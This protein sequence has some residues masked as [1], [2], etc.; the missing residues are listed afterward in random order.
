MSSSELSPQSSLLLHLSFDA[1]HR[2]DLHLKFIGPSQGS[3]KRAA[4]A[5][6]GTCAVRKPH[7][8]KFSRQQPSELQ[9]GSD[10][11][12]YPCNSSRL[13]LIC[14]L[15]VREWSSHLPWCS[16]MRSHK[17]WLPTRNLG[18]D[19]RKSSKVLLHTCIPHRKLRIY[20]VFRI[21]KKYLSSLN[22]KN[23]W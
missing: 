8:L 1:I 6:P 22:K 19:D 12:T 15:T 21:S 14:T 10:V 18:V 23:L 2:P 9:R 20:A 16:Q 4:D 11:Q 7:L 5:L 3:A 17:A 13:D